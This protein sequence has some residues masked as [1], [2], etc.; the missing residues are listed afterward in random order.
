DEIEIV[1]A[2]AL[3]EELE[4]LGRV[5][6][7]EVA[8]DP[9]HQLEVSVERVEI[10]AHHVGGGLRPGVGAEELVLAPLEA[11]I[12]VAEEADRP[13]LRVDAAAAL[14]LLLHGGRQLGEGEDHPE[15]LRELAHPGEADDGGRVDAVDVP[16]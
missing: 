7:L 12:E 4:A 9:R 11:V 10:A 3:V 8:E 16:E 13:A 5:E 14:E 2:I 6:P 15:R 1:R